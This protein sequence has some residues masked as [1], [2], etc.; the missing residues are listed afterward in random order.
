[1]KH[2]RKFAVLT[3]ST[4]DI[5][6]DLEQKYGIDILPFII[7]VDGK[8][9]VERQDFTNEE[10]YDLLTKCSGIPVTSQITMMRFEEKFEAYLADGVE[11]VLYVSI[12]SAGSNTYN[13]AVMAARSFS[14]S[15]PDCG[16]RIYIVDSH[17]YSMAYGYYVC[18]AARKLKNGADMKSVVEYLEDKFSSVEV[19]LSMYTLKYVKKSGRVSAAAAFAG[20][21]LGL[22]P[23]IEMID[24]GTSTAAKVR[25]DVNVIPG[26]VRHA[27]KRRRPD[28]DETYL[29]G[30]TDEQNIKMLAKLCKAEFG[31]APAATFLIGAAVA[32][33]TGPNAVAIVYHG[34]KRR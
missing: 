6:K 22:R 31:C 8:S 12:N 24:G 9:Y 29:V 10:Y 23:I 14:E 18:E 15:H 32:T 13:S 34:E 25:G 1:M 17:T 20:E 16:M 28:V 11:E 21:L 3:D 30:G 33:N 7:T 5:P 2:L 26:L 27:L 4:C 19:L